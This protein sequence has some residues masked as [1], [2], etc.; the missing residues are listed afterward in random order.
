MLAPEVRSCAALM[1]EPT[2]PQ[3]GVD[4]GDLRGPLLAAGIATIAAVVYLLVLLHTR[5]LTAGRPVWAG[6]F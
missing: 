5:R 1:R 4:T 3:D 2:P 6:G